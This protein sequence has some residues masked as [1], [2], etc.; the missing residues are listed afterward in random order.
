[1]SLI[2]RV[3]AVVTDIQTLSPA[4]LPVFKVR[5]YVRPQLVTPDMCPLLAV[6]PKESDPELI[7]TGSEYQRDDHLA[8]VWFE[9]VVDS[10]STGK[11]EDT[12]S[13]AALQR[14]E[15]IIERLSTY[16]VGI[17]GY[18]SE[19]VECTLGKIRYGH[20]DGGAWGTEIT[21]RVASWAN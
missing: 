10:L 19:A 16:G 1:M 15:A 21:L 5:R 9:N 3:D 14:A 13:R 17:P 6:F 2:S 4:T 12:V 18:N 8:V 20:V 11:I 7:A